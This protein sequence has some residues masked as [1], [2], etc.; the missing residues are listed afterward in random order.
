[1]EAEVRLVELGLTRPALPQRGGNYLPA[2][3]V[4]HLLCLSRMIWMMAGSVIHG[5]VGFAELTSRPVNFRKSVC[6]LLATSC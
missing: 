5:T 2:R 3:R 4:G 6:E 1:M